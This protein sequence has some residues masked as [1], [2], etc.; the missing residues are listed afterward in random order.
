MRQLESLFWGIIA[1]LGALAIQL[2]LFIAISLYTNPGGPF[3][4]NQ[5]LIMPAFIIGAALTEEL[6]KYLIIAKRI[7]DISLEMTYILNSMLVGL[8]FFAIELL[9][10][11]FNSALPST[12][13]LAQL[14]IVHIGTAGLM[15]YF[16]AVGNPKKISTFLKALIWALAFHA[17]YNLL[18]LKPTAIS[19]VATLAL[20]L[21]LILANIGN[22]F[23]LR[24]KLA[25]H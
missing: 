3:S 6:L 13:V 20:L 4:L 11:Y 22:I 12:Q 10:I 1:A 21:L 17:G 24:R 23:R 8:G 15:G 19:N 25:E 5:F 2:M 7:D 18:Q 16:I 14:A 9:L